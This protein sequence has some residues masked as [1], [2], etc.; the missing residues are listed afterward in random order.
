MNIMLR[1]ARRVAAHILR[2]IPYIR[3]FV[4]ASTDYRVVTES[5][6]RN[7]EDAGWTFD[8]TAKRQARAYRALLTDLHAGNPRIDFRIAADAVRATDLS[9]PSILEIGCGNGYYSEVFEKLL[10]SGFTYTGLDY[11]DPMIESARHLYPHHAFQTGDATDLTFDD[12]TFD[13]VFDGVSLMHIMDYKK[14]ISEAARV[15]S[16]ACIFHSVPVFQ[17][18][19]TTYLRKYAYGAPVSEIVFNEASLIRTFTECGLTV[20]HV[21][22]GI[23]YNV[24]KVTGSTSTSKTFLCRMM[25]QPASTS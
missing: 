25:R 24:S 10:G 11:A 21:W 20:S 17:N 3:R 6:A 22:E 19:E 7:G 23:P 9:A 5:V 2:H 1:T 8:H 14:A 15:A 16:H 4:F 18:R 13:I 12:D